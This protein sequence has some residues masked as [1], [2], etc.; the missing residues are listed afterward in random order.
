ME[1]IYAQSPG[2]MKGVLLGMLFLTEGIAMGFAAF[3]IF[4][5]GKSP[6]FHFTSFF[7][8]SNNYVTDI[9]SNCLLTRKPFDEGELKCVDGPLFSYVLLAVVVILAIVV[10][11]GASIKYSFR[12]RDIEPY[13]P[14][15]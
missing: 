2:A 9:L 3:I 6:H 4:L 8:N 14:N 1:F 12:K 13:N 7:G 11:T 10:F 5:Q 15:F